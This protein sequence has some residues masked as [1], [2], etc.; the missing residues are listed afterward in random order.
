VTRRR[1]RSHPL[2]RAGEKSRRLR[3]RSN[4]AYNIEA[5]LLCD[6]SRRQPEPVIGEPFF[7][8]FLTMEASASGYAIW[9]TRLVA[10]F[11]CNSAGF[12]ACT[13]LPSQGPGPPR[14][15]PNLSPEPSPNRARTR[16]RGWQRS[17]PAWKSLCKARASAPRT[18]S[19][20]GDRE[21]ALLELRTHVDGV[22]APRREHRRGL[23]RTGAGRARL[24]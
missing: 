2:R 20:L 16:S 4:P 7:M 12:S 24:I 17:A 9:E 21:T 19:A 14:K 22:R 1:R 15:V 13:T 11:R 18:H 3:L 23:L 6:S 10:R 5:G 8:A